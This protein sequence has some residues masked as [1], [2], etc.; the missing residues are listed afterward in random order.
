M[1]VAPNLTVLVGELVGARL[2]AHAGILSFYQDYLIRVIL[3]KARLFQTDRIDDRLLSRGQ[4][5]REGSDHSTVVM[6]E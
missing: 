1:A 2:I 4:S 3:Q 5:D 6:H